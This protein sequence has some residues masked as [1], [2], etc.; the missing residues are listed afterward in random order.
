MRVAQHPVEL[1]HAIGEELVERNGLP[2]GRQRAGLDPAEAQQVRDETVEPVGFVTDEI[3]Q[4]VAHV[5]VVRR[6]VPQ[7]RGH[8]SDRDERGAEIVRHRPQQRRPVVV[9]QLERLLLGGELL[10]LLLEI[11][12]LGVEHVD[13]GRV[14]FGDHA[15]FALRRDERADRQRHDGEHRERNGVV[16]EVELERVVRAAGTA[17]RGSSPRR[18]R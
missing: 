2:L 1:A 18:R 13:L 16:D 10:L 12:A 9:D 5:V 6:A 3:E 11:V 15:P 4:L 8:R 17:P 14:S 7:V